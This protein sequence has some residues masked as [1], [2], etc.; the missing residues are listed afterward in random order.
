MNGRDEGDDSVRR[1]TAKDLVDCMTM[2]VMHNERTSSMEA[3]SKA[4][5]IAVAPPNLNIDT[6]RPSTSRNATA[7]VHNSPQSSDSAQT[8]IHH[9]VSETAV[10][11]MEAFRKQ[12]PV[13]YAIAPDFDTTTETETEEEREQEPRDSS[14]RP[15]TRLQNRRH[16]FDGVDPA[17]VGHI[18]CDNC[19]GYWEYN[20]IYC[21]RCA[22]RTLRHDYGT[23]GQEPATTNDAE[24]GEST[25]DD[26][27]DGPIAGTVEESWATTT[28]SAADTCTSSEVH[29]SSKSFR[30]PTPDARA[31]PSSAAD[32]SLRHVHPVIDICCRGVPYLNM[33]PHCCCAQ[34]CTHDI[35]PAGV[36]FSKARVRAQPC[37]T[38]CLPITA[39]VV[40]GGPV[41]AMPVC[42]CG[43]SGTRHACL[44]LWGGEWVELHENPDFDEQEND[45]NGLLRAIGWVGRTLSWFCCC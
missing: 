43:K 40:F 31:E 10:P 33:A 4:T 7:I 17:H 8:T 13:H 12:H 38:S 41:P 9:E 5:A 16:D 35:A 2:C 36:R 37:C 45:G 19:G 26:N 6:N 42:K 11:F 24:T 1:M 32:P 23:E 22:G 25:W 28:T 18:Y 34:P 14:P 29:T 30:E 27:A 15:L 3:L 21:P 39:A 20:H 44:R